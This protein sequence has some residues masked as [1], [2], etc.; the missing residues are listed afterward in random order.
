MPEVR[1]GKYSISTDKR[2]LNFKTIY[3]FISHS[4][5]AEGRKPDI[6]RSA[7]KNSICFGLY[8]KAKQIGFARVIS[9]QATFAYLA[10]VFIIEEYRGKGLSKW[11]M[12]AIFKHEKFSSVKSWLLATK[13]AH[14]LYM[15]FG[16]ESLKEPD[17]FM[18]MKK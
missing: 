9:D 15:K 5:W 12:K 18:Q 1:K 7:I 11:F 17:K 4:Y 6:M 14:G 16:F 13:D 2:K 10:D 3:E 8:C